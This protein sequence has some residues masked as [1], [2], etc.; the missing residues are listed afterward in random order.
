MNISNTDKLIRDNQIS[1][2]TT[3]T[4][5]HIVVLV[6]IKQS[7][8]TGV[9][10][11]LGSFVDNLPDFENITDISNH[12]SQIAVRNLNTGEITQSISLET[13]GYY[14]FEVNVSYLKHISAELVGIDT[15]NVD[16]DLS[17]ATL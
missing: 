10:R 16:V 14:S 9:L 6:H 1:K 4:A 12:F 3:P 7:D 13:V 8:P 17:Y 15:G 11:I 2:K 5:S